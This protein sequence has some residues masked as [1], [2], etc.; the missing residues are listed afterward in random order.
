MAMR[1]HAMFLVAT[2]LAALPCAAAAAADRQAELEA[3]LRMLE[4]A[5]AGLRAELEAARAGAGAGAA[6]ASASEGAQTAAEEDVARLEAR[7]AAQEARE[8]FR[9]GGTTFR[10]GGFVKLWSAY[11]VYGDGAP[12]P[13]ALVRDF[14]LP[15]QIPVGGARSTGFA[16]HA[17]QTRLWIS[18][19]ADAGGHPITGYV[20]VDFQTAPG[21]QGT[22]RTTNG[23]NLAVRRA[24][25]AWRGFAAGQDW[26]TFQNVGALPE[27]TDFI[28]PTEGTV[29]VRQP[30]IR[31][32]GKIGTSANI[33]LAVEN[34]VTSSITTQSVALKESDDAAFP[35]LVARL[36]GRIGQAELSLAGIAHDVSANDGATKDS[37]FGWGLS[38]A[39]RV[40]FGAGRRHDLRFMLT[41]GEGI[42]HYVGLNFAPD[43]VFADGRVH[44]VGLVAGFAALRIG[45][46]ARMRST[47]M[48]SFQEVDYPD[49]ALPAAANR[50]AWSIAGNIFASPLRGLDLGLELRHGQREILSGDT[51]SLDRVEFITRYTF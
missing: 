2:A 20:E 35:D 29:F 13:G 41:G 27:T 49:V 34:P 45:W 47:L 18:G 11:S 39:G 28:G 30:L 7:L 24:T 26:S 23:Y 48:G 3:R 22:A 8:G 12:A 5:V 51:G 4:E 36:S 43:G 46:S 37:A 15:Q 32:T 10:A 9:V 14:Y 40:P 25:I 1:S 17:K 19:T 38:L 50:S 16:A 42:G 33:A 6:T 21:T 31:W 44:P